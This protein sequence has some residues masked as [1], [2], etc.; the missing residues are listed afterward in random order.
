MYRLE[1]DEV[2][3]LLDNF[4]AEVKYHGAKKISYNIWR[5]LKDCSYVTLDF[6]SRSISMTVWNN[7][8]Y[9]NNYVLTVSHFANFLRRA[10][11]YKEVFLEEDENIYPKDENNIEKKEN[12]KMKG[13]NFDFGK[14]GDGVRMSPYGLAV[15]NPKGEWVSYD[16][17]KEEIINVDIFNFDSNNFAY[18]IP[19]AL[20]SVKE[21]DLIVHTGKMVYVTEVAE[22][23][24]NICCV[25]IA[26]GEVKVI[27]PQKSMFGFNFV[28]KVVTLFD[29][30]N[31][32]EASAENPF[33]NMWMLALMDGNSN[34]MM[35]PMLMMTNGG[36]ASANFNP[37]MFAMLMDKNRDSSD[38]LPLM[39]MMNMNK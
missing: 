28:T 37:M 39:L 30:M 6:F 8:N 5:N 11:G 4:S 7:N 22:D 2:L 10:F 35:L 36:A 9:P 31:F 34:D 15:R 13:F 27:L 14:C 21:G 12:V 23:E 3:G 19:V 24:K 17:N 38:L 29:G 33:G 32:G 1:R 16:K 18:K 25:D 20:S 26:S